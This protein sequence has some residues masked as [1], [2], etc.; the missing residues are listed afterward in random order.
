[1]KKNLFTQG[2]GFSGIT[3]FSGGNFLRKK[4][5]DLAN[6]DQMETS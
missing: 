5:N 2:I 3:P 6:K 1:M 4:G